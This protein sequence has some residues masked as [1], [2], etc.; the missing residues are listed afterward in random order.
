MRKTVY[1][2]ILPNLKQKLL[3][4]GTF[5]GVI[6]AGILLF[7]GVWTSE[8]FLSKWGF[9][10][11]CLGIAIISIGMIP[12]R[13]IQRLENLPHRLS[14]T[15]DALIFEKPG[16]SPLQLLRTE[17][18]NTKFLQRGDLYGIEVMTSTLQKFFFPYFSESSANTLSEYIVH[19]KETDE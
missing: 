10:I 7:F 17:I 6:G 18:I 8:V 9:L 2:S 12:L 14:I 16:R 13:R 4:R 15:R 1:S 5:L 3:V 11:F 19:G